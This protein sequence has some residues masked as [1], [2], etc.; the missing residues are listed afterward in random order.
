MV[1]QQSC[2]G[3]VF[4]LT[5]TGECCLLVLDRGRVLCPVSCSD[6]INRQS[7][8]QQS[9][10]TLRQVFDV[11]LVTTFMINVLTNIGATS[12]TIPTTTTFTPSMTKLSK[13]IDG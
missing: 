9:G 4:C 12:T 6:D 3:P 1:A 7:E 13:L 10:Y 2:A 8:Q 5:V 11:T